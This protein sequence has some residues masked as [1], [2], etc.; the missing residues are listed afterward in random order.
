MKYETGVVLRFFVL[1]KGCVKMSLFDVISKKLV[2]DEKLESKRERLRLDYC[3]PNL[4]D[5]YREQCKNAMNK[6]DNVIR[7]R[8]WGNKEPGYPVHREHGW[9]L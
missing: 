7:K 1:W 8:A 3:N 9:Y 4:D 5:D 6:L 2:S